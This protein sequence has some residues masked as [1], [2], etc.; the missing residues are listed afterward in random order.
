[1]PEESTK[2]R[3]Y[4]QREEIL[5]EKIKEIL[6]EKIKR[7]EEGTKRL[8]LRLL[9]TQSWN[10]GNSIHQ[11]PSTNSDRQSSEQTHDSETPKTTHPHTYT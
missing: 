6:H 9:K 5:H 3:I 2:K 7:D 8:V 10:R 4:F 11:R 1:M